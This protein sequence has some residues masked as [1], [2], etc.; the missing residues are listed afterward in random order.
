MKVQEKKKIGQEQEVE[1]EK[2]CVVQMGH[3]LT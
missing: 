1:K 3:I 2:K